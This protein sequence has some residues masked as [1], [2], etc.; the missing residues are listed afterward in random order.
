MCSYGESPEVFNVFERRALI[1]HTCTECAR[2]IH[3]AETYE[4][5]S[6][7]WD[8]DWQTYKV[9]AQCVG[10]RT[11]LEVI[12]SSWVF[13]EVLSDLR[14]H[15]FEGYYSYGLR[16]LAVGIRTKWVHRG[17]LIPAETVRGWARGGIDAVA[18]EH[19]GGWF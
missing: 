13:G 6:G 15:L 1:E 19:R 17:E 18:K 12:C 10:A 14:E 8:G 2:V 11:W 3:K 7:K 9:C 5:T 4:Y 16:R